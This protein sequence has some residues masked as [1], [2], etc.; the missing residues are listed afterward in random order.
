MLFEIHLAIESDPDDLELAVRGKVVHSKLNFE[1]RAYLGKVIELDAD[2]PA[3]LDE[4]YLAQ[5]LAALEVVLDASARCIHEDIH[6]LKQLFL[7]DRWLVLRK[8]VK[9]VGDEYVLFLERLGQDAHDG[10]E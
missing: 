7:L 4:F 8:D 9:D 6:D 3:H 2:S 10:H 5:S 1:Q